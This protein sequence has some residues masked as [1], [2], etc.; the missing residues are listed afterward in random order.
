M[1]LCDRGGD[2]NDLR[3]YHRYGQARTTISY[4][5][6]PEQTAHSHPGRQPD[7]GVDPGRLHR[8]DGCDVLLSEAEVGLSPYGSRRPVESQVSLQRQRRY[9]TR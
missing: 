1:K 9:H 7:R 5:V 6:V 3:S 8:T 4:E 2:I